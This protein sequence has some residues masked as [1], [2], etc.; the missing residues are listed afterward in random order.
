MPF[1]RPSG[2]TADQLRPVRIER[3]FTRHAEGSVLVSFG[4]T[5]VLCT[6]SVE[7]RVPNFLRGK[8]EGWVT[9]EYGMLPRSTHTRSDR[10]AARGKQGGRT[11][12][13]QRL[14]GRALRACVD[15][16]ALGERTITLDCDVLQ[17]DGGTRTAAITGAYV[18]LADA[19][20][21]LLKRGEIKKHPLIGA[22]A[23]V[24]V[25]IYR[26]EPVLDLDYPE[27]S[28]CDTDMNVVMNDGGG[29]IELQ[30]TAEGH[31]FRRD[32]LNA[33]LALAEKGMGELFALQ[34]AA[35]AG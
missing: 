16:N 25:G 23:A 3:A 5:R 18:A 35:L 6:A 31:A 20:N 10:E 27:D 7:N 22:V 30:G 17:A 32:E 19:V 2:R 26:G 33:L 12:E 24:S 13:I 4:D 14:I 34:R 8:G 29:F 15:R 28:D 9:A 11:L 1:S 21:L